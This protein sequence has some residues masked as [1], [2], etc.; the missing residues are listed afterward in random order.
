VFADAKIKHLS[1]YMFQQYR[2][3]E[4][5][6]VVLLNKKCSR[7]IFCFPPG[8]GLGIAFKKI[9]TVIS[10][11]SM[12]SFNYI[13]GE[14]KVERYAQ[15]VKNI[16]PQGPYILF[17]YSSGGNL[18]FEVAKELEKQGE[19]V[20][21]IILLD[22]VRKAVNYSLSK[23][24][25]R[26]FERFIEHELRVYTEYRL[27]IGKLVENAS[28]Y[29]VYYHREIKNTGV[30]NADIHWISPLKGKRRDKLAGGWKNA[31]K[32]ELYIYKGYGDHGAMLK[33]ETL[34]ANAEVIQQIL[35]SVLCV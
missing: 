11:F 19:V 30:I 12:Y 20:S 18:A 2:T 25:T 9:A 31:T 5:Q 16:Q 17:G 34:D 22:S 29:N 10:G 35:G 15:M 24:N 14:R 6:P 27:D 28:K 26:S 4:V 3:Q 33:P 32:K 8:S 21:D 13:E 23:R 1:R 7:N